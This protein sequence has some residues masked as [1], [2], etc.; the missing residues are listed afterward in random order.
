MLLGRAISALVA[1]GVVSPDWQRNTRWILLSALSRTDTDVTLIVLWGGKGGDGPGGTA[2]M[3]ELATRRG[4][5]VAP[6]EATRLV[7]PEP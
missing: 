6:L 3:V 2:D 4:V 5:K 7:S 1:A